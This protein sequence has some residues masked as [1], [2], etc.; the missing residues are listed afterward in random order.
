MCRGVSETSSTAEGTGL[1][2]PAGK[3]KVVLDVGVPAH[4]TVVEGEVRDAPDGLPTAPVDGPCPGVATRS[5]TVPLGREPCPATVA[6]GHCP[7]FHLNVPHLFFK[8]VL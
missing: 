3:L 7:V 8:R 6:K 4:A 2:A 5:G 1:G